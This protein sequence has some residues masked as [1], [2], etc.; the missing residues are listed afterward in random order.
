M[1]PPQTRIPLQP[2]LETIETAR[3][4]KLIAS[5]WWGAARHINYFGDLLM[6]LAW[7]LPC[8]AC[9]PTCNSGPRDT[10]ARLSHDCVVWPS[11]Y[12]YSLCV[13]VCFLDHPRRLTL[14]RAW[15]CCFAVV[16]SGFDYLLPYF[17]VIYFAMLLVH[18]ERR[19]DHKCRNKVRCSCH[20][21]RRG[22]GGDVARFWR[23][24]ERKRAKQGM[25]E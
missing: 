17:Y 23:V 9:T 8:G 10:T 2:D 21:G 14:V 25:E 24:S 19:D 18:R 7:C 4:T 20:G 16:A 11:P 5:G 12:L 3:G 22:G 15:L 6:A 1:P 13:R